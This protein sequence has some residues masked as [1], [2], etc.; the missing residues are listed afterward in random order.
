MEKLGIGRLITT[1]QQRDAIHV[2][3]APVTAHCKLYPAEGVCFV[4]GSNEIVSRAG[5]AAGETIGIVDPFLDR[6]VAPGE[7]F[8][9]FLFPGT[10]TSLRHD[11]T[12]PAFPV[13]PEAT[14]SD[15]KESRKWIENFSAKINGQDYDSLMTVAARFLA[16]E[17]RRGWE[18][19]NS[20]SYKSIPR[21]EW[22]EFWSHYTV[23]TGEVVNLDEWSRVPFT[24][25][26]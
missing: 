15:Q 5:V 12:H 23:M 2:A 3:V 16:S 21:S 11:W 22:N 17:G 10:V 18:Y 19:D 8:W 7:R 26:C 1:P 24:C 14:S 25:S 20:E 6:V 13:A 9:V 4:S